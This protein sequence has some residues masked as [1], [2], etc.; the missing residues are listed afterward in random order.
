MMQVEQGRLK[1][2]WGNYRGV[3]LEGVHRIE[4]GNAYCYE[5]CCSY[6]FVI[7]HWVRYDSNRVTVS[8][9]LQ[10]P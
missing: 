9:R 3:V 6:I 7:H 1:V 8:A 10:H 5:N 4:C 2:K